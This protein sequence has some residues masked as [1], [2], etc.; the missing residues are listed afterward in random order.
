MVISL[1]YIY[2]N[3]N[4]CTQIYTQEHAYRCKHTLKHSRIYV[5]HPG[6]FVHLRVHASHSISKRVEKD[7][8]NHR[9]RKVSHNRY[10]TNLYPSTMAKYK[11]IK[12]HETYTNHGII[13]IREDYR[14]Q[15]TPNKC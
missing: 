15:H 13:V 3:I 1:A 9:P 6:L 10:S 4:I 2:V 5:H 12:S 11:H 7:F 8:Q 14:G